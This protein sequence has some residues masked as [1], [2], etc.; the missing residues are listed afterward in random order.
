LMHRQGQA[1][2]LESREVYD[3]DFSYLHEGV[4]IPHGIYDLKNNTAYINIGTSKDTSEF[5]CDSI[6]RWWYRRGRYDYSTASSILIVADGGGSNS[7]RHYLFKQDLQ[8]L[9]DEIGV[10]LRVAHYPPY[11]SKWNPIEHRVFPHVT[12]VLEGFVLESY[13]MVKELIE[14]AQTKTGLKIKAS[15]IDKVYKTGRKVAKCF[16]DTM[17]IVFDDKLGKWN[18]V[19]KPAVVK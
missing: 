6:K 14:T 1:Y 16:K 18:Y 12:R 17:K 10:E 8:K 4:A 19:A 3:H 5:A 15:I 11:T 2:S 7:S 9:S 13:D